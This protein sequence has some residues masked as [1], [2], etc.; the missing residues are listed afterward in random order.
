MSDG[1]KNVSLKDF[2]ETRGILAPHLHP[3]TSVHNDTKFDAPL[4]I[5]KTV[6]WSLPLSVGAFTMVHG[7][8]HVQYADIGRYCSIA[9]YVVIGANEHAMPWISTNSLFEAPQLFGWHRL[10]GLEDL[11]NATGITFDRSVA[12]ITIGNDVWIGHGAFIKGGVTIGDGAVVGSMAN[13]V[14]DVPPYAIVVGNPARVLRYR[15]PEDIILRC[16]KVQWWKYSPSDLLKAG[17][18]EVGKALDWLERAEQKNEISPWPNKYITAVE[19]KREGFL[20]AS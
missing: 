18:K 1:I 2:L 20:T 13:V 10:P 7:P 14:S 11:S 12:R 9:P 8:G 3:T 19:L 5:A 15:F 17:P 6:A 4:V 16:L